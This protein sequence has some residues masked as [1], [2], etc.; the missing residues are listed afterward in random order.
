MQKIAQILMKKRKSKR[1]NKHV[2]AHRKTNRL[3]LKKEL[4]KLCTMWKYLEFYSFGLVTPREMGQLAMK[5]FYIEIK[6][7]NICFHNLFGLSH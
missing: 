2:Q 1:Q 5:K 7:E 4:N 3:S 6:R